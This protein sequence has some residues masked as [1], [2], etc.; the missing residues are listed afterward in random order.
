[1]SEKEEIRR[2]IVETA[3]EIITE[4]GYEIL[5]MRK[6]AARIDYWAGIIYHY[7]KDK[8]EIADI[9]CREYLEEIN[10]ILGE[11]EEESPERE[12]FVVLKRYITVLVTNPL[13][14][15]ALFDMKNMKI[16]E[17]QSD[18]PILK[19]IEDILRSAEDQAIFRKL[20]IGIAA[21]TVL[22]AANGV[23]AQIINEKSGE[24]YGKKLIDHYLYILFK[25]ML[26]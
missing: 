22:V 18:N 13:K 8:Q 26:K 9:V 20:E 21:K 16:I 24:E 7:F 15:G 6:I 25:G 19:R 10:E 23:A 3:K 4:D 17:E 1:M 2:K 11:N 14:Y 5:S 12:F